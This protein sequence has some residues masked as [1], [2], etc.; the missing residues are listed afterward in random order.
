LERGRKPS[1]LSDG[2]FI[3]T[4]IDLQKYR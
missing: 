2:F 3:A 1:D 4:I